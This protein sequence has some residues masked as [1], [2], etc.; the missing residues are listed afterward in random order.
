M[1]PGYI[2]A[3]LV[4]VIATWTLGLWAPLVAHK[5][6]TVISIVIIIIYYYEY[7]NVNNFLCDSF[8]N[9]NHLSN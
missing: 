2:R 1:N 5:L 7:H 3:A 9:A 8:P 4:T 6:Y